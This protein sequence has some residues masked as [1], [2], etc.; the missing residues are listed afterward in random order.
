MVLHGQL[1][2]A[3]VSSIEVAG[4]PPATR[5]LEAWYVVSCTA[6]AELQLSRYLPLSPVRLLVDSRGKNLNEVLSHQ[7]LNAL[8]KNIKRATALAVVNR[9]RSEIDRMIDNCEQLAAAQLPAILQAA[10][11]TMRHDLGAEVDRLSALRAHNPAIRAE[12]IDFFRQQLEQGLRHI[13]R[14]EFSLEAV[15]VVVST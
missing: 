7:Q 1:G 3:S 12:E 4:L 8:C 15:R 5:L 10:A 11:A 13:G 6:P 9:V 14:G 2:N